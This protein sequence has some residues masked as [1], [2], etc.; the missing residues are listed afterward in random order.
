MTTKQIRSMPLTKLQALQAK[1]AAI[2]KARKAQAS[3]AKKK[4]A[5]LAKQ[6]GMTTR[7]LG[8][9]ASRRGP[10]RAPRK[11]RKEAKAKRRWR[12]P[13]VDNGAAGEHVTK[14]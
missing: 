8:E 12:R 9:F 10:D 3:N 14:H 2:I 13:Q 11:S 4:V 6:L 1:I 5:A 7:E